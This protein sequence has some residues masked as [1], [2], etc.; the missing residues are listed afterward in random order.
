MNNR[1]IKKYIYLLISIEISVIMSFFIA[2]SANEFKE[3]N[4]LPM[5]SKYYQCIN[6]D[7]S[8]LFECN[9]VMCIAIMYV[10]ELNKNW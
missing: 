5:Y 8:S 1:K 3:R 7:I 9:K 10:K 4:D 2:N 6:D